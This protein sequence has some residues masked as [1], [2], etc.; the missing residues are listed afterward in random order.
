MRILRI[1]PP[2]L[3]R[4]HIDNVAKELEVVQPEP[5][6]AP[7]AQPAVD[8][9]NLVDGRVVEAKRRV[10]LSHIAVEDA[11]RAV[12]LG[13]VQHKLVA[14]PP[15]LHQLAGP[16][17]RTREG[18]V[19][20]LEGPD[21]EIS[22]RLLGILVGQQRAHGPVSQLL[23]QAVCELP[24]HAVAQGERGRAA[25]CPDELVHCDEPMAMRHLLDLL[26]A[27]GVVRDVVMVRATRRVH[28]AHVEYLFYAVV[29]H[30]EA[31]ATKRRRELDHP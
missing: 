17:D 12:R 28:C 9:V 27:V 15:C 2:L 29:S 25:V 21:A 13:Y 8:G 20:V 22:Q 23:R 16:Q 6:R 26:L 3:V 5:R 31:P 24:H 18:A 30:P 19:A 11:E 7:P 1:P 4:T 14:E 10:L